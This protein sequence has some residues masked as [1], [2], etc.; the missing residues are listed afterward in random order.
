MEST[1][2]SYDSP[3]KDVLEV[4][5]SDFFLLF[6]PKI[7]REIDWERPP[8]SLEQ[9]LRKIVRDAELGTRFA[10]K[11]FQVWTKSGDP[12]EVMINIEVQGSATADFAKRI[13]VYNYRTFDRF[14]RPVV[15]P[16]AGVPKN[17]TAGS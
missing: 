5:L 3:W 1:N 12:L 11:L 4:Y 9:E 8:L 14:D 6:L 15:R 10:D 13:Y 16:P 2:D 7:H 17:A